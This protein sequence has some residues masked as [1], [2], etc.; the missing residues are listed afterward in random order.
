MFR[1]TQTALAA[2]LATP[3]FLTGCSSDDGGGGATTYSGSTSAAT[4][5]ADNAEAVGVAATEATTQAISEDT[6]NESNPFAFAVA[7]S[8]QAGDN[9]NS[10]VSQIIR[11]MQSQS[12]NL[13]SGVTVGAADFAGDPYYC[14]GSVTVPD[15]FNATSGSMTFSN[16]CYDF[17]GPI[18]MNGV[19]TFSET[20]TTLTITYTNFTATFEGESYTINSSVTCSLDANGFVT[21]CSISSTYTGSDGLIYRVDDFTVSGSPTSGFDVDAT[22]YHPTYGSVTINTTVPVMFEC[23]G[24]QPSAGSITY[25]GSGGTSGSITFDSCSSYTYC[26]DLG[27]GPTCATGTW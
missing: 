9:I 24:P 23:T 16:F 7:S 5:S 13:V 26:F 6:A 10:T 14:G 1:Y 20:A 18:T 4:I 2:L 25:T 15:D 17:L 3:I 21:S 22:F 12:G 11:S 19:I 8:N 27:S